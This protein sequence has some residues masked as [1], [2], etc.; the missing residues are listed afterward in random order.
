M[1]GSSVPW[2]I[3]CRTSELLPHQRALEAHLQERLG[4]LFEVDYERLLYD[5]TSTYFEGACARH[6]QAQ[7]G[8][9]RDHR[10]D[11]KPVCIALVVSREGLP[12]GYKGCR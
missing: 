5:I 3:C 8:Y 7:R 11:C 10:G 9:S 6:E 12:L 1:T 4:E 2:T